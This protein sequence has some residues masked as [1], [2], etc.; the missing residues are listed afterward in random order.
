MARKILNTIYEILSTIVI[1]IGIILIVLY[2]CGIR[3]YHVRSGSMGDQLP[4][5]CVCFVS[6]YSKFDN[7]KTGDIISFR[8]DDDTFV[9]HRAISVTA[10]GIHTK[11]DENNT[12]DPDV[13]TENNY[14]G[15]T[16]FALPKV[17]ELFGFFKT[18]AGK[19]TIAAALLLLFIM[20]RMYKKKD[21]SGADTADN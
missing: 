2:L 18:T 20:G 19:I 10:E 7:I 9:T 11:G 5:G 16:V 1:T 6:T 12:E 15:K 17:G 21:N 13:V 8:V 4:V 3:F 14:I